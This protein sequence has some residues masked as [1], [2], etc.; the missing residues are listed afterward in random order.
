MT[1]KFIC[2]ELKQISETYEVQYEAIEDFARWNLPE[3]TGLTRIDIVDSCMP[4]LK[5]YPNISGEAISLLHEIKNNFD[6]AFELE[7]KEYEVIWSHE[8]MKN[9]PFWENQRNL[10]KQALFLLE[11]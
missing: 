8:S 6:A 3:E 10:P 1:F 9:H 5:E 4:L 7:Q 11:G 2:R